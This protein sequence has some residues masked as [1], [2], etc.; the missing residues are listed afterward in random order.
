MNGQPTI[1]G[2]FAGPQGT[3]GKYFATTTASGAPL[4]TQPAAGT[5]NLQSGVCHSVYAPRFKNWNLGLF[6]KFAI[7]ETNG[8]EFR[9][10]AY[11]FINHSNWA[12]PNLTPTSTLFGEITSKSATNPR[13]LQLSLRFFF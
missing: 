1:L 10:E 7:T 8:L 2:G 6:K 12:G 11:N 13:Q 9:S 3:A 4:F 5:F